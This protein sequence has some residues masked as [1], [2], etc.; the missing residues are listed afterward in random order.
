MIT[1]GDVF[2]RFADDYCKAHGPRLLENGVDLRIVQ[3]LL[4]HSS[5]GTTAIYTHLT[6][7]TRAGLKKILDK[8]MA[9]L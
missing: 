3:I 7:P 9:G 8:V 6:E 1:L 5:I 4:G 2:R